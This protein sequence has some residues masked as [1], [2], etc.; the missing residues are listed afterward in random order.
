MH[1]YRAQYD[2]AV[3]RAV[4]RLPVLAEYALPFVRVGGR[5]SR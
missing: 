1:T 5:S 4:A 2:I 3:S